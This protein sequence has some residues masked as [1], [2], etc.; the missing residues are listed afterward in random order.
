MAHCAQCARVCVCVLVDKFLSPEILPTLQLISIE[1]IH[2]QIIFHLHSNIFRCIHIVFLVSNENYEMQLTRV[3]D[4]LE[5]LSH[6]QIW[7]EN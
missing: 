4:K 5:N 1:P 3:S 6:I 7:N 2:A